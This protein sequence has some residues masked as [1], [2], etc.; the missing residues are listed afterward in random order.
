MEIVKGER[1]VFL[2]RERLVAISDIHIGFEIELGRHGVFIPDQSPAFLS[3]I[4]AILKKTG[5]KRII[6]LGDVKHSFSSPTFLEEEKVVSFLESLS[7]LARVEI[8]PGNHDGELGNVLPRKIKLHKASGAII[9]KTGF[10]HGHSWPDERLLS[11]RTLVFSHLHPNVAF[12]DSL[13]GFHKEPC[14]LAGLIPREKLA[15]NYK[16]VPKKLLRALVLPAFNSLLGGS[17]IQD[18]DFSRGFWKCIDTE[19]LN[20]ILIDGT[21]LGGIESLGEY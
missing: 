7:K 13:G 12:L 14:Y 17:I 16:K 6:I 10:F 19:S 15:E 1:A 18:V 21:V 9:G 3:R 5:A 20:A 2:P 4:S 11:A 8:V